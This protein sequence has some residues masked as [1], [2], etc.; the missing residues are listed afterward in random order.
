MKDGVTGN[1]FNNTANKTAIGQ[2]RHL[3]AID[4][5]TGLLADARQ[6]PSP[7][8]NDRPGGSAIDLLVIH[9]ISLP[10]GQFGGGY[11]QQFFQNCLTPDAHPYFAEIA[12]LQVSAHLLITREGQAIQFVPFHRRAWHAGVSCFQ[13]RQQCNDF[14]IGI[15]LEGA[16]DIPY[17][18]AQYA[19]L[20]SISCALL[21]AYPAITPER[22]VGHSDIAPGRKTDPGPAFN[23]PRYRASL[24][25]GAADR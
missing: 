3:D 1:T 20:Q 12:E 18:D 24:V 21:Q 23:W 2:A 13:G 16:D 15:E 4:P 25:A 10:P 11:I 9:N 8:C 17:T 6:E 7:N 5:D 14:S 22:I 19:R